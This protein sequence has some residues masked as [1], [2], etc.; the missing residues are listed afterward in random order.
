[1]N[2]P[3]FKKDCGF[4]SDIHHRATNS[5]TALIFAELIIC[6]SLIFPCFWSAAHAADIERV[7]KEQLLEMIEAINPIIIDVRIE[8]HWKNSPYKIN[9]AVRGNPKAFQS[10]SDTYP[11]TSV[12]I[13]YCA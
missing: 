7:T 5:K 4:Q 6:L 9:G 8:T 3:T 12:L 2:C 10:W 13:L 1:M 11:R